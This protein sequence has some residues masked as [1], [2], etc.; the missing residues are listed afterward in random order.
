MVPQQ[1]SRKRARERRPHAIKQPGS[2][3][4]VPA[5]AIELLET[6]PRRDVIVL[7]LVTLA[8]LVPF[9]GKAVHIDD[10][11]F[12]WAA[13][14]IETHP[15]DF[16]G[17]SVNWY[18]TSQPMW[19][20]TKNPPLACYYLAAV[21]RLT[22]WSEVPLHLA[23]LLPTLAAV[24]GAYAV[25]TRFCR[26]ALLATFI[27]LATPAMLV[28]ATT[29]MCDV[30]MLAFW[31]WAIFF[32]TRGIDQWRQRDLA[33][34]AL[35]A[36]LAPLT[37]YFAV[38]LLPLMVVYAWAARGK[39][40]QWLPWLL[41]PLVM[42]IAYNAA[43][44]SMYGRGLL[45]EAI[46]YAT[47]FSSSNQQGGHLNPI[48]KGLM[49]LVFTGGCL[50]TAGL[51]M[52]PLWTRRAW[53]VSLMLLALP[54]VAMLNTGQLAGFSIR[55]DGQLRWGFVLQALLLVLVG[56][57]L[58][59]VAIGDLARSRSAA[60]L[61]LV[62]WMLGT[63]VFAA[64]INWSVNARSLLPAAPVAA[65]LVV[66]WLESTRSSAIRGPRMWTAVPLAVGLAI[67]LAVAGADLRM[68]NA[69]RQATVQLAEQYGAE[70]DHLWSRGHWGFQ[71]YME[72]EGFRTLDFA[73]DHIKAGDLLVVGTN[74][75][76]D[77]FPESTVTQEKTLNFPSGRWVA[78]MCKQKGAGFYSDQFGPL[79]FYFGLV[80]AEQFV[81]SR[82]RRSINF[83]VLEPKKP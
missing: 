83:N 7:L 48:D 28:S 4:T 76:A 40:R 45:L 50:A 47:E 31:C 59:A 22:G 56:G 79:P 60:S 11:L 53:F 13:E 12:L 61:L 51:V 74:Q 6:S 8:L 46:N 10:P 21:A 14:H 36:A 62:L 20:T 37:K 2:I 77:R 35:L 57:Q 38:S 41:P 69:T 66:R 9:A 26:A 24:L 72:R 65:L 54:A 42:L 19:E 82:A 17:F 23:M 58:F 52:L 16:Y 27:F 81:V 34:A 78:T 73:R 30:M 63:F 67:A 80:P 44:A 3:E 33:V 15:L 70:R 55:A 68:A 75:D 18:Y 43:T 5:A 71:Y 39:A 25:A 1:P 64:F 32:W 49:G 29:L